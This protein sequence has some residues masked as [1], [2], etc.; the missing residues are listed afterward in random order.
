MDIFFIPLFV[1]T[2]SLV[3][4][5][6]LY[7]MTPVRLHRLAWSRPRLIC[8]AGLALLVLYSPGVSVIAVVQ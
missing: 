5:G 3:I 4:A 6:N 8:I 2:V 1:L 7:E